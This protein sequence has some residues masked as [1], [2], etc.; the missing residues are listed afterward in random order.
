MSKGRASK[1]LYMGEM[2]MMVQGQLYKDLWVEKEADAKVLKQGIGGFVGGA[3]G[4]C[5]WDNSEQEAGGRECTED[6]HSGIPRAMPECL[7]Y[8]RHHGRAGS[9]S[10]S[11]CFR[12]QKTS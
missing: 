5:S 1:R 11:I 7:K 8:S 10:L 12:G 9:K 3:A 4:H 6:R 2:Q